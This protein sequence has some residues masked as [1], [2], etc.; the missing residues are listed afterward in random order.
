MK[1]KEEYLKDRLSYIIDLEKIVT[2][3]VIS[4]NKSFFNHCHDWKITPERAVRFLSN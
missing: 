1:Q 3:E 4:K 2:K